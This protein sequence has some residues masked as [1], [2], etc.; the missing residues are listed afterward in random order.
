MHRPAK[1][2][3]LLHDL[4]YGSNTVYGR[5]P[6][7]AA[8]SAIREADDPN[9]NRCLDR[10]PFD[11]PFPAGFDK[12]PAYVP[13]RYDGSDLRG[14]PLQPVWTCQ[15][16]SIGQLAPDQGR[17]YGRCQLGGP[18]AR[19]RFASP[20]A[21]PTPGTSHWV[22]A[23]I[24]TMLG[25]AKAARPFDLFES[26]FA[27]APVGAGLL[28]LDGRW[29]RINRALSAITGL[30]SEELLRTSLDMLSLEEDVSLGGDYRQ[31]LAGTFPDYHVEKRYRRAPDSM[32]WVTE[33]V[34][35]VRD[36]AGR[37]EHGIVQVQSI[38]D[39]KEREARHDHL[40]DFDFL[41]SLRNRRRFE[42]DLQS[43]IERIARYGSSAALLL[44][45]LDNFKEVNDAF[46]HRV[47]DDVLRGVAAVLSRR[48]RKADLLARFGGDE[49]AVLLPGAGPA[50]A[51]AVAEAVVAAVRGHRISETSRTVRLTAS[52]GVAL[53]DRHTRDEV[54]TFADFAMYEAKR[55]GGDRCLLFTPSMEGGAGLA[56]RV[57]EAAR[58]RE[59]IEQDRFAL[60]CQPIRELATGLV[61]QYEVLLRLNDDEQ[62]EPLPP[63]EFMYI[64]E[65]FN[66]IQAI[67]AMVVRK[68][69]LLV[70]T[71]N[72][73]GHRLT[74]SINL[75]GKSLCSPE[76][77][78]L[79]EDLVAESGIAPASLVFELTETAAITNLDEA[80]AFANRLRRLGCQFALDDFGAGFG[81]FYYL[82]H[83]PLDYVKIDGDFVRGMLTNPIDRLV[84]GTIVTLA[85]GMGKRT[86]AEFVADG[87]TLDALTTAGVDF[88][89]GYFIAPPLPVHELLEGR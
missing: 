10:C 66:L 6:V 86:I 4:A 60:Y 67:D 72:K 21:A 41:T 57:S 44:I 14:R 78:T 88:A 12:C 56:Q 63:S 52:V 73:A 29:L 13:V 17:H 50:Q 39:R 11:R 42:E 69:V 61:T 40:I 7:G 9:S 25:R 46:G 62:H 54:C 58:L 74:L 23:V 51:V 34:S 27:N 5:G 71:A 48:T 26:A 45:D 2:C 31:V 1:L 53:L 70:A 30:G 16:L 83:L 85:R 20:T 80:C 18:E 37:P 89:Q 76:L 64:A 15:H 47:G 87:P 19:Q 65:R 84:V 77:A 59:A 49:F 43:E 82:K 28:G 75:S 3:R 32:I 36:P 22:P 55:K 68:A 8:V 38:A 33:S 79:I 35:L 81:S 24:S